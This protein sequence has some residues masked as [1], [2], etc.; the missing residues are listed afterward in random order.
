MIQV[1]N[2]NKPFAQSSEDNKAVILV[3][4][5][6]LLAD[7]THVL[8]I[9]SGTGQHAVHFAAHFPHLTWQPTELEENISGI[10]M[11]MHDAVSTN[12][13]EPKILDVAEQQWPFENQFDA[14]FT[15]NTLHIMSIGHVEK[16]F[17]G[18]GRVLSNDSIF[19]SY[20]PFNYDGKFSSESN[21]RFD[22]WLKER[23]T[24]SGI[25]D[26]DELNVFAG[27]A[28]MELINDIEMPVN[29]RLLVWKK[30]D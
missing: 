24:A 15:A 27:A 30:L 20:G 29:N 19:I 26:I 3:Q 7:R 8:E 4:L 2:V 17:N 5:S 14:A 13:T 22:R 11:W 16:L 28:S 1:R 6:K 23:D 12:I 21:A 25:R 10:E 9:G 18:L